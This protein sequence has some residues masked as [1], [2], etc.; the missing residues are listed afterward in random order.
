MAVMSIPSPT[1]VPLGE[2]SIHSFH[3]W[4]ETRLW[5]FTPPPLLLDNVW[6]MYDQQTTDFLF[7]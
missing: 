4:K 1:L 3:P 5:T 7:Y 6:L 2:E